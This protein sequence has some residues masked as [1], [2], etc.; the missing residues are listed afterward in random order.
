MGYL[1]T[2]TG[3]TPLDAP[4]K[5]DSKLVFDTGQPDVDRE[6]ELILN[7]SGIEYDQVIT[8]SQDVGVTERDNDISDPKAAEL[9]PLYKPQYDP[10]AIQVIAM[11]FTC[12]FG[13]AALYFATN[14]ALESEYFDP[15]D[16]DAYIPVP[17]APGG[18]FFYVNDAVYQVA[19]NWQGTA[20]VPIFIGEIMAASFLPS[21]IT[22]YIFL[23]NVSV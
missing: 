15:P 1:P 8:V 18:W 19:T 3:I 12:Q 21:R 14:V 11:L 5:I 2:P 4:L 23:K 7:Y 22:G 17:L 20:D 10:A 16:V 6:A 9:I 13:D